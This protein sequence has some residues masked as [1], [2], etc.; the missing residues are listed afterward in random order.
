MQTYKV[1]ASGHIVY[2]IEVRVGDDENE[3]DAKDAAESLAGELGERFLKRG[4]VVDAWIDI[5]NAELKVEAVTA[6]V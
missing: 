5:E 4:E 2:A 3:Q 1:T 6:S